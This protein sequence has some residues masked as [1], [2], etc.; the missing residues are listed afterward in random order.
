[1]LDSAH[2]RLS[3]GSVQV[4][5]AFFKERN[6]GSNAVNSV[7]AQ[8]CILAIRIC[9]AGGSARGATARG[10]PGGKARAKGNHE[11]IIESYS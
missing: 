1:M 11:L 6:L 2:E 9:R 4:K 10:N 3:Q 7:G 8:K 5:V